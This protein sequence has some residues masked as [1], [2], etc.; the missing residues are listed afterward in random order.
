MSSLTKYTTISRQSNRILTQAVY[1]FEPG[2][3]P[4]PTRNAWDAKAIKLLTA[5]FSNTPEEAVP[6]G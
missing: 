6:S 1:V 3:D 2:N 4:V 5:S